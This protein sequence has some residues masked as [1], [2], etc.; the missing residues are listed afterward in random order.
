M[1][2]PDSSGQFRIAIHVRTL[3][4]ILEHGL[5]A[6][7]VLEALGA[8]TAA[9]PGTLGMVRR[10]ELGWGDSLLVTTKN[11]TYAISRASS[12]SWFVWGGWFERQGPVPAVL[13][14][15]GCTWG[16]SVIYPDI[17][18]APGLFLEFANGVTTTRIRSVQI[19]PRAGAADFPLS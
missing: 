5:P 9:R 18:A 10:T 4:A 11:S 8:S 2:T 6:L 16:G 7:Q 15:N 14:I 3:N 19:L 12:E 1:A 17:L 13:G